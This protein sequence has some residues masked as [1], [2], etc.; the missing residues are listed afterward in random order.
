MK[1]II[2]F[3]YKNILIN[4]ILILA[5]IFSLEIS[6][7]IYSHLK[8]TDGS[9]TYG[10][11]FKNK[12]LDQPQK[13]NKDLDQPQKQN[14]DLDQ[15]QKQNKDLD[16]P[17][18][19]SEANVWGHKVNLDKYKL[20]NSN[21]VYINS[22]N[23]NLYVFGGSFVFGVGVADDKN[24]VDLLKKNKEFSVINAALGGSRIE[25]NIVILKKLLQDKQDIKNLILISVYNNRTYGG[26]KKN[27][28]L[29]NLKKYLQAKSLAFYILNHKIT[30]LVAGYDYGF[31][32]EKEWLYDKSKHIKRKDK[33]KIKFQEFYDIC[34]KNNINIIIATMP[35]NI[36]YS[37]IELRNYRNIDERNKI[38]KKID[39]N[40]KISPSE[41]LYYEMY[42][43]NEIA[44]DFAIK[45]KISFIESVD[46]FSNSNNQDYFI[47]MTHLNN[48]GHLKY[49]QFIKE[50]LKKL[51]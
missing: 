45:Y 37:I 16:Q 28:Y 30:K 46:L 21:D 17:Q 6:V 31:G 51:L 5:I 8:G 43:F 25:E 14:K 13:Q 41:I 15:S 22:K 1:K 4:L 3:F 23:N 9:L 27:N 40:K 47:D 20:R 18:K 38:E 24:W 35:F 12:D 36:P 26:Y 48:L 2:N 19:Q 29:N 42:D 10:F 11:N 33:T 7:R 49:Y 32:K 50:K 34:K 39:S 44:R